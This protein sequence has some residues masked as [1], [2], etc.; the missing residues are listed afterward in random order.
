MP[1]HGIASQHRVRSGASPPLRHRH[2]DAVYVLFVQLQHETSLPTP[3]NLLPQ[4]QA[5]A[6]CPLGRC[7]AARCNA[8][9]G[10]SGSTLGTRGRGAAGGACTVIASS[11]SICWSE[12]RSIAISHPPEFAI[13][14]AAGYLQVPTRCRWRANPGR[15]GRYTRTAPA[16]T[17]SSRT[18]E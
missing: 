1:W 16:V 17:A 18:N 14:A 3:T 11:S 13:T 12:C 9:S 7:A 15:Y 10:C 4:A 5:C 2:G 6:W 8:L